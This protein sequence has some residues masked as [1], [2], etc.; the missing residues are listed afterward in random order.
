MRYNIIPVTPFHQNCSI[1]WCEVTN[2][3][4][5]VDP[6]GESDKLRSE[7]DKLGVKVNK[8]LLTH[9]H[10]DHVGSA[11]ELRQYY[12]IPII[13][14]NKADQPLLDDLS[15]QCRTLDIDLPNSSTTS[16]I[17]DVWLEDGDTVQVGHEVFNIL[18][19]PGH[20]PGHIVY[21]NKIRKFIVMGDVLFKKSIGR[22]D[23]PGGSTAVLI[24]SI[25]TK[26]FPLGDDILFLPGHG[27][28]STLG[29]ERL[30]N[31][32]VTHTIS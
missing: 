5:L 30:N 9:G 11:M 18:H 12:K 29:Y 28:S 26:L 4:V 14:P 6:G 24:N 25:K 21:W 3:A 15:V 17:P 2:E 8:I 22:T 23:L 20:S 16:V 7:I 32:Y 27:S 31:I 13:G 10:F 1:I 19:C